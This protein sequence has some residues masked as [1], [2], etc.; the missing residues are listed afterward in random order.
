MARGHS[1]LS[2]HEARVLRGQEELVHLLRVRRLADLRVD[3]HHE[4][5]EELASHV[6]V[7][8]VVTSV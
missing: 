1:C 2:A 3:L 6:R 4:P 7:A 5:T 8:R